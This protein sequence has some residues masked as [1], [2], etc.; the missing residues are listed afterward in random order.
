MGRFPDGDSVWQVAAPP[1]AVFVTF[2]GGF[3]APRL[4][5]DALAFPLTSPSGVGVVQLRAKTPGIVALEFDV[6][7]PVGRLVRIAAS[8][9]EVPF[10]VVG[11]DRIRVNVQVLRGLS[12]LLIKMDPPAKSEADA[13]VI[14]LPQ[15]R[16]PVGDTQL[17]ADL[18]SPD[19]GF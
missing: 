2:P 15:Q 4:E 9:D 6:R 13:L 7:N 3:A 17:L 1:A 12:Q 14:A 18:L 11:K 16:R 19:P 10:T 5:G 8:G